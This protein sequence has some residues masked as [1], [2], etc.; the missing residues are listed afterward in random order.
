MWLFAALEC[1]HA[2]HLLH[3]VC[4]GLEEILERSVQAGDGDMNRW[5]AVPSAHERS[6][7]VADVDN[8]TSS[9]ERSITYASPFLTDS[10]MWSA[11]IAWETPD[12]EPTAEGAPGMLSTRL[13]CPFA[14]LAA[15]LLFEIAMNTSTRYSRGSASKLLLGA[16]CAGVAF[17]AGYERLYASSLDR[18]VDFSLMLSSAEN[19]CLPLH[20]I[21][22][23]F[24]ESAHGQQLCKDHFQRT[25]RRRRCSG[26]RRA[27]KAQ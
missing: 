27:I 8:A 25:G 20:L 7:D 21:L 24:L 4:S 10:P 18:S 6:V 12:C 3:A 15:V 14:Q 16:L 2:I 23:I 26:E 1:L 13:P 22:Q 11:E 5:S 19:L 9:M 17:V